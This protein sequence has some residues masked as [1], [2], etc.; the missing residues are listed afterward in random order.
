MQEADAENR[1]IG[2][3]SVMRNAIRDAL[4][5]ITDA[6]APLENRCSTDRS[7]LDRIMWD[8]EKHLLTIHYRLL[9]D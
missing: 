2:D 4:A 7:I 5:V 6:S 1:R 3:P 8:K 9:L